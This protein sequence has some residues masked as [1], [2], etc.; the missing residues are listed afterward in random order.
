MESLKA[1]GRDYS[2]RVKACLQLLGQTYAATSVVERATGRPFAATGPRRPRPSHTRSGSNKA[3]EEKAGVQLNHPGSTTARA[4]LREATVKAREGKD[5]VGEGK[6]LGQWSF[7]TII[8]G[9]GVK[10]PPISGW[11]PSQE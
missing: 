2:Q 9:H 7:T 6:G 3:A 4:T 11:Y 1:G 8:N 10:V 5:R